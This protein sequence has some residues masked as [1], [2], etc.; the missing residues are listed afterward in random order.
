MSKI[1]T[2]EITDC[3]H[4]PNI[5]ADENTCFITGKKISKSWGIPDH[6]KLQDSASQA[7]QI[8]V[9]EMIGLYDVMIQAYEKQEMFHLGELLQTMKKKLYPIPPTEKGKGK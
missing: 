4:C 6:C 9:G 2:A 7:G 1:Y 8:P 5:N 3:L